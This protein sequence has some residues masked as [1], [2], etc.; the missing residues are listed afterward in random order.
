MLWSKGLGCQEVLGT[1]KTRSL[2]ILR[3]MK[4]VVSMAYSSHKKT[5]I[6]KYLEIQIMNILKIQ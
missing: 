2:C 5:K 3:H 6:L 1:H 4:L